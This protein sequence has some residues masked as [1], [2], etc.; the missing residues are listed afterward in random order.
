M[1]KLSVL[2]LALFSISLV[3]S[4][5]AAAFEGEVVKNQM[6]QISSKALANY[7]KQLAST[8]HRISPPSYSSRNFHLSDTS[9]PS[10]KRKS[11]DEAKK[12]FQIMR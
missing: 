4:A 1:K 7:I 10:D 2:L 3:G 6:N 5:F 9:Y 12:I 8:R 11:S